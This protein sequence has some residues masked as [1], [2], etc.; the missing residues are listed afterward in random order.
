MNIDTILSFIQTFRAQLETWGITTE[1]LIAVGLIAA[2]LFVVSLREVAG[3]FLKVN[4]L[5]EE[6]RKLHKQ[7]D[8]LQLSLDLIRDS[9][10]RME[11]AR[12]VIVETP[13]EKESAAPAPTADESNAQAKR[14][15]LDH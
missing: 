12:P 13:V 6:I 10:L 4:G 2:M 1:F 9:L 5:R 14:F 8:E 11:T 7:N 15:T 3:W